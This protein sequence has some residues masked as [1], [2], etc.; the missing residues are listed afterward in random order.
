MANEA[1]PVSTLPYPPIHRDKKFVVLS[2]WDGTIT[3][4]DSNDYMTDN[5]GFGREKRRELNM[6]ILSAKI[7]FRDAFRE[8]LES[9]VANGHKFDEC[10][11]A[12]K[13]DIVLDSGFKQFYQYCQATDTPV[14]IISSGMAPL[15]RAVLSNLIGD[16]EAQK[17]EIVS[18]EVAIHPDGKWDILY[19]H[20]SSGYGHDKSQAI[21]PYRA[22]PDSPT[23][24]F[25]GDGVSDMS[26]ARHADVLFVK[27]KEDGEND[28]AL[29]CKRE[30]I[31][32]ILFDN[33]GRA[34]EVV[35]S[36]VEG[37]KTVQEVLAA[38]KA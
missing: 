21:L 32:H 18:N 9:V 35:R 25:F 13:R 23:I 22:L 19:R 3:T 17:I 1:V 31:P 14:V 38:G 24:F 16:E 6:D 37:K 30:E 29:Y 34:L 4:R 27:Q 20:P 12:L 5:F 11:E 8:M 33:F 36:V 15:I 26:A 28:L 10:K 2:D 7:T